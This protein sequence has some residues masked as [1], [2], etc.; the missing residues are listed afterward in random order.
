MS[1]SSTES[2]GDIEYLFLVMQNGWRG[3]I[4]S[5]PEDVLE[6]YEDMLKEF[7]DTIADLSEEDLDKARIYIINY[8]IV[9]TGI[10]DGKK[11]ERF[12][13]TSRV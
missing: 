2:M 6:E 12:E 9:G 8:S 1:V 11:A 3:E 5:L 10:F 13:A 7:T 4:Q